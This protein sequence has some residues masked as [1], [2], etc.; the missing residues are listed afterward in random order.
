MGTQPPGHAAVNLRELARQIASEVQG[1]STDVAET[2]I[3]RAL[4]QARTLAPDPEND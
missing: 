3:L 2:V 4:R 1:L